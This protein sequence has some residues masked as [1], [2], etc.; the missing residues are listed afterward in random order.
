MK[1]RQ[2][3]AEAG[4]KKKNVVWSDMKRYGSDILKSEAFR[5]AGKE[6]HHVYGTVS[7]HT[8]SVCATSIRIARLCN[9]AGIQ[10]NEKDL[11]EAALCH[12]LGMIGREEK[13]KD[14]KEAWKQH[15]KDSLEVARE[16]VPDLSPNAES[17]ILSH[18][19]PVGGPTPTSKEAFILGIA[20]KVGSMDDWRRFL[21]AK[22][23]GK[24]NRKPENRKPENQ[25]PENRKMAQKENP[26]E[27]K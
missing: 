19:W 21:L 12:D 4:K 13:Y 9:K 24:K 27:N 7:Q 1:K 15:P 18:M 16:L 10:V 3:R 2:T 26:E 23:K 22:I 25:K 8:L 17:M 20:D 14:S 5:K 6:Q 11:V